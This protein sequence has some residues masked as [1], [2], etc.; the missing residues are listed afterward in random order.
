MSAFDFQ[1][2]REIFLDARD[3]SPEARRALLDQRCGGQP[4]LRAEVE[5]LLRFHD[6][7]TSRIDAGADSEQV[8]QLLESG[9]MPA[10]FDGP[11]PTTIGEYR[12]VRRIGVGGMAVVYEAEQATPRR[13]VALKVIHAGAATP[14][15][16]RRLEQ[17]A[18]LLGRLQHPGI[19][20]V[21]E[22]GS[23]ET[24][25]GR[26]PFIAI[27]LIDGVSLTEFADDHDLSTAQRLDL[28]A[29]IADAVQHAHQRGVIHR[30]LKPANI[31]VDQSGQPKILDFGVA[32]ATEADLGMTTVHTDVGQLIGTLPYMSPEQVRGNPR[33]L[34][35]RSD[36]FALGVITFELLAG[37]LPHE[38]RELSVPEA[39]R[40]IADEPTPRLSSIQPRLRG[41]VDRIVAHA[42][43]HDADER[44]ASASEFA[45]DLR[46]YLRNEPIM[47][48][49]ASAMYQLRKFARRNK[50][51]VA[52]AMAFLVVLAA[53]TAIAT[54]F[55]VGQYR[56]RAQVQRE[57]ET[58]RLI[59]QF[60]NFM[61]AQPSPWND[62]GLEG[63]QQTVMQM[64]D[65]IA[66]DVDGA[67]DD[68][69]QVEASIRSTMGTTYLQL[70]RFEDAERNLQR[71]MALYQ[72]ALGP[73]SPLVGEIMTDLGVASAHLGETS[74]AEALLTGAHELLQKHRDSDDMF[75]ALSL[76]NLA[77]L[78]MRTERYEEA[79][80]LFEQ[81]MSA[82][83]GKDDRRAISTLATITMN[84]GYVYRR[85]DRPDQARSSYK[86][87]LDLFQSLYGADHPY[88]AVAS[89]NLARLDYDDGEYAE[90]VTAYQ[91]A[92][93]VF[94]GD[95]TSAPQYVAAILNNLAN[96]HW[97][98]GDYESAE[99]TFHDSL[100]LY[101]ETVGEAHYDYAATM[102]NLAVLHTLQ[103][104]WELAN[105]EFE[106]FA[107]YLRGQTG[108]PFFRADV[109]ESYRAVCF[110]NLGQRADVDERLN[111]GYMRVASQLGADHR[112]A[113]EI[114]RQAIKAYTVL[115]D[116]D[117][118]AN[119]ESRQAG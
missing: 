41:D 87:G 57:L 4:A 103:D 40:V 62:L 71:A 34:D 115:G 65:R 94:E 19:A 56:A 90:A 111:I 44:Y 78:H 116:V 50:S 61:L 6:D 37:R 13:T 80:A 68:R 79:E 32:R 84:L 12:I 53:S 85:T 110:A 28:M 39:A 31:L 66:P 114:V 76:G 97:E 67:F 63:P 73:E 83:D 104:R 17:E 18:E 42:L 96:A 59:N 54:T 109:V 95:Y 11:M 33:D 49:P 48:R 119:W 35:A 102:S 60:F 20:Q 25:V 29:S 8:L 86:R 69:P 82:L 72:E 16:Q 21:F 30:D 55:A 26:R 113:R 1:R 70:G 74:D 91:R 64:L 118:V 23:A 81:A 45:A 43:A 2:V 93:A 98:L 99:K 15:I 7:P 100:D 88:V 107:T 52:G 75:V 36:V 108:L 89:N 10:A 46:R 92:L 105:Q 5:S 112:Y 9:M 14:S 22:A 24:E 58:V 117:A 3:L 47:A 27:E 106:I 77:W 51:L 101:R 38:L